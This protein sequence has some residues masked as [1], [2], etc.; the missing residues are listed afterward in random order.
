MEPAHSDDPVPG[1][2]VRV[3]RHGLGLEAVRVLQVDL[4]AAVLAAAWALQRAPAD[5]WFRERCSV[6]VVLCLCMNKCQCAPVPCPVCC[7]R[8]L[9]MKFFSS[10]SIW[11][12]N[13]RIN[14]TW[15]RLPYLTLPYYF[16]R[17]ATTARGHED[18]RWVR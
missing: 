15:R 17:R 8:E 18:V 16:S 12:A 5:A 11:S 4:Q 7:E 6:S 3:G 1:G 10:W 14:L 13:Q 9:I 2:A